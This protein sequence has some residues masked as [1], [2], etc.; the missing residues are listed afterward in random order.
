MNWVL[1]VFNWFKTKS[2]LIDHW[3]V[4]KFR[5]MFKQLIVRNKYALVSEHETQNRMSQIHDNRVNLP[6]WLKK[7]ILY[8]DLISLSKRR[9]ID[10][11][12]Y[13]LMI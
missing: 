10:L 8:F 4:A 2:F 5:E 7:S 12:S 11:K 3:A 9:L 13:K 6:N 1:I